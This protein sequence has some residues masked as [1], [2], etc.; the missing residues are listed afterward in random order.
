MVIGSPSGSSITHSA[1]KRF[2]LLFEQRADVLA[3]PHFANQRHVLGDDPPHFL[4]D[5][6]QILVGEGAASGRRREVVIEAVVGRRSEGDLGAG[7]EL[8]HRLGED[9]REVVA[10]QLQRVLLVLRG[11]QR[12]VRIALER[13]VEV[14]QFAVDPRRQRRL[15][16]ARPDRRRDIRR[17]RA[18]G[19]FAHRTVGKLDLE[20]LG[21]GDASS[22]ERSNR[23]QPLPFPAERAREGAM[24]IP[25]ITPTASR[26]FRP[27]RRP[28]HRLSLS[29]ARPRASPPCCSCPA[30]HPTWKA[31]RP[32]R[33]T[34]IARLRELGL[35]PARLFGDRIERRQFCRRHPD[36]L[37]GG[38]AGGD[39]PA[40]RRPA[41][42]RRL[43][44]GRLARAPRRDAAPGP[45]Q[46]TAG[47]RRRAR[48]H[49]LGLRPRK[50]SKHCVATASWSG[51]I[52]MGP[53]PR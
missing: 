12:Q 40:D 48:F 19:H 28:S 38:G 1:L 31:P 33:S 8:L 32:R 34:P 51:P 16:Q 13:A 7:I 24:E 27:R 39:R 15:G 4:L 3:L 29:R 42:H 52:P 26:L 44:D 47:H 22:A 50:K 37:A 10:D 14:A 36:P 49:R 23:S 20:H 11:D 35:P 41:D 21:H 53:S 30:M 6:R 18:L 43:V 17:G 9:M 5:R 2:A 45:G 25:D 46:G